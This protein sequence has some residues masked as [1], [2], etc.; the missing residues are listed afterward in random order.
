[1]LK[2][3]NN[4]NIEVIQEKNNPNIEVILHFV[5]PML[6]PLKIKGAYI[7]VSA[8]FPGEPHRRSIELFG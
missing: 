5:V 2:E 6:Y 8:L 7:S 3:K 1:M 4:P